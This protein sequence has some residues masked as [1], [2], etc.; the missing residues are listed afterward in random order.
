MKLLKFP[1][2]PTTQY[3]IELALTS[4]NNAENEV[5]ALR[6]ILFGIINFNN[7]FEDHRFWAA[8]RKIEELLGLYY[9]IYED[10]ESN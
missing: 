2:I 4:L 9:A 8:S 1:D 3:R 5:E 6:E 7:E 10:L